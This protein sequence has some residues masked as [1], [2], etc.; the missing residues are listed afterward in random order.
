MLL[1]SSLIKS[2]KPTLSGRYP[3]VKRTP[4][5]R[6]MKFLLQMSGKASETAQNQREMPPPGSGVPAGTLA[7]PYPGGTGRAFLGLLSFL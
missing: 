2:S 6:N 5:L 4:R 7:M 3:F 1:H